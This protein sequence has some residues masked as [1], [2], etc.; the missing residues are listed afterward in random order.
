MHGQ[1]WTKM[2]YNCK[3]G[4]NIAQMIHG[5]PN[6]SDCC[7]YLISRDTYSGFARRRSFIICGIV[8]HWILVCG[9]HLYFAASSICCLGAL[10]LSALGKCLQSW[11]ESNLRRPRPRPVLIVSTN[12]LLLHIL[13]FSIIAYIVFLYYCIYC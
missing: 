4:T 5:A 11:E 3:N 2:N 9:G 8:F 13:F 6:A 7:K 12:S 10:S 1:N